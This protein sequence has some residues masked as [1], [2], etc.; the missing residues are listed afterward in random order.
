MVKMETRNPVKHGRFYRRCV[1]ISWNFAEGKSV[2]TCVAYVT[3]NF[4]W[5]SSCRC[6]ADRTQ[7]LP[8]PAPDNVLRVLQISSKSVH[9]RRSSGVTAERV[10][11][12]KTR[13][14]V[15]PI[16]GW[17]LASSRIIV[18]K[19]YTLAVALADLSIHWMTTGLPCTHS[20]LHWP[21]CQ[22]LAPPLQVRSIDVHEVY[23][24]YRST[25][26]LYLWAVL[27]KK[28]RRRASMAWP[29]AVLS[30][31]KTAATSPSGAACSRFRSIPRPTCQWWKAPTYSLAT[32]PSASRLL[33]LFHSSSEA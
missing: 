1:Q 19:D 28:W 12:A 27:R 18:K 7:N 25:R 2:T 26:V 32:L 33:R 9:F 6:C 4:A 11:T 29:I 22:G 13:H 16:V 14:K 3:K 17:R 10:N 20:D 24:R 30:I 5:L 8:G 21:A 31:R 23:V 15:N